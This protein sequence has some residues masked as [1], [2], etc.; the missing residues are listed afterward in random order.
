[1]KSVNA[2]NPAVSGD[3]GIPPIATG[4]N[5]EPVRAAVDLFQ[6]EANMNWDTVGGQWKQAKGKVREQWGKLTDD[7]M[8]VIAGKR[9]Q[10]IG[11][12]QERYGITRDE[13]ERQVREFSDRYSTGTD[14]AAAS[15]RS[16]GAGKP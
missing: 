13:A 16:R 7:D 12:I 15:G 6:G 3:P 8:D 14:T 9:D 4:R 1:L 5:D 11:R 2:R 10:L